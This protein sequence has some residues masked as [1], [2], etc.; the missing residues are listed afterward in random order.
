MLFLYV[1]LICYHC[2]LP[3][4]SNH[5]ILMEANARMVEQKSSLTVSIEETQEELAA[6][7]KELSA[8]VQHLTSADKE[9]ASV[10]IRLV[11]A[12]KDR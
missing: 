2:I 10:R 5:Q 6:R 4:P 11:Q 12:E 9:L 1:I 7:T 8:V 3:H